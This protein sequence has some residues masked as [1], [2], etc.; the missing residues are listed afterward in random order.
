MKN[1]SEL[2]RITRQIKNAFLNPATYGPTGDGTYERLLDHAA[3]SMTDRQFESLIRD[4]DKMEEEQR[5]KSR[6]WVREE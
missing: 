4:L 6:A 2:S 1:Q 5:R 3:M